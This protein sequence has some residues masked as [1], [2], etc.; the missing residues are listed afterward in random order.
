MPLMR[1]YMQEVTSPLHHV[2]VVGG[3]DC[4]AANLGTNF[5]HRKKSLIRV[6]LL[7]LFQQP[8]IDELKYQ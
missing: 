6:R 8:S 7:K 4:V 5:S 1:E 3:G 2:I